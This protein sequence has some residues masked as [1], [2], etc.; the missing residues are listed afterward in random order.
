MDVKS[1]NYSLLVVVL[2]NEVEALEAIL[3][4]TEDTVLKAFVPREVL[5]DGEANPHISTEAILNDS[6]LD[7]NVVFPNV[8]FASLVPLSN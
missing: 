8:E 5:K 7:K 1:Q 3:P 4:I 2:E 6:A